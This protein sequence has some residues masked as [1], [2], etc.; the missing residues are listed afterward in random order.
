MEMANGYGV[1][2]RIWLKASSKRVLSQLVKYYNNMAPNSS[3]ELPVSLSHN[4]IVLPR[5]SPPIFNPYGRSSRPNRMV[6]PSM[7]EG[8]RND[9][10]TD[11][12]T[13][14]TKK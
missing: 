6:Y 14:I 12:E 7:F 1:S 8:Q 2:E 3:I 4:P 10:E 13:D 9:E 11:R 5:E